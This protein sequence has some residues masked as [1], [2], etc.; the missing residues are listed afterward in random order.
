MSKTYSLI[1][2]L[3]IIRVYIWFYRLL[4]ITFGGIAINSDEKLYSNRHLKY[5][6]YL[7]ALSFTTI[8][9]TSFYFFVPSNK[10]IYKSGELFVYCMVFATKGLQI[11]HGLVNLWYLNISCFKFL[12]IYS[13][14][15]MEIKRNQIIL[16]LI[17]I[18]HLLL[19]IAF[20]SYGLFS[21]DIIKNLSFCEALLI[22]VI[23]IC[24]FFSF[25]AVS[26]LTCIISIHFYE[27]LTD[28]K[29]SLI[30]GIDRIKGIILN[31]ILYNTFK[32]KLK[33][34]KMSDF[35]SHNGKAK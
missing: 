24:S 20:L 12:E 19:P 28:I 29:Q 16:F 27:L 4:G 7:F 17:W 31:Q 34:D 9:I 1:K 8:S 30:M 32:A 5:F 14:F 18:C 25:W 23:R 33:R 13:Q 10:A 26:F 21:T 3:P 6:G 11:I 2:N 35:Q 22:F 15:Q